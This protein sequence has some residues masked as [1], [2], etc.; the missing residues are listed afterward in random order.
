VI[1]LN[2]QEASACLE[3]ALTLRKKLAPPMPATEPEAAVLQK[4]VPPTAPQLAVPVVAE[5]V[6]V[7]GFS[8]GALVP[9]CSGVTQM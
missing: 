3:V 7:V 6:Y 4:P 9:S 2:L 1:L 8:Q 5:M